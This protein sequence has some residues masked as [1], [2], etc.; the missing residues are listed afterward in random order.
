MEREQDD[1][2]RVLSA[3]VWGL[4]GLSLFSLIITRELGPARIAVLVSAY[5]LL[6]WRE[7]RGRPAK[8]P[9][10]ETALVLLFF[11]ASVLRF[12]L[13]HS[14]LLIV[15]DFLSAFLLLKCAFHKTRGDQGQI[16]AL[17][18]F[19]LLS[20]ATLAL[21]FTFLFS[22][23]LYI[24][25]LAWT[26]SLFTLAAGGP[27]PAPAAGE[28]SSVLRHVA[29]RGWLVLASAAFFTVFIFLFFPR[30]SLTV[31]QGAFLG[32]AHRTGFTENVSLEGSGKIFKDRRIVMRVETDPPEVHGA[33]RYL[34]GGSLSAFDG[35]RWTAGPAPQNV[36]LR[37]HRWLE[38]RFDLPGAGRNRAQGKEVRSFVTQKIY[39]EPTDVSFLFA[40]P[41]AETVQV[42]LPL[43]VL[44]P[45]F[46]LRRPAWSKGRI[47]Y[48]VRSQVGRPSETALS[49][50]GG[51]AVPGDENLSLPDAESPM[52]KRVAE[53]ARG[54]V[55]ERD[56]PFVKA[57]KLERYVR[58]NYRY[59]LDPPQGRG[60]NPLHDFLFV[61]KRGTCEHYA[62]A[63]AVF[64]RSQGVPARVATGFLMSEKNP[65]GGYYVV[66]AQDAHAWVEA[67]IGGVW[68][69]LDPTPRSSG[70]DA[71]G[72]WTSLRRK[73]EYLNFLWNARV[74]SYDAETQKDAAVKA[75]LGSRRL[76]A[77]LDEAAAGLKSLRWPRLPRPGAR[78]GEG[79][80][81]WTAVV[82]A[83]A[84]LIPG[85]VF[86]FRRARHGMF[87]RAS[88]G[89][90]LEFY[91]RMLKIL[92][93][94][95]FER[96][97]WE[98]PWEFNRRVAD[99]GDAALRPHVEAI[100]GMFCRARYA[101]APLSSDD[102]RRAA[103]SLRALKDSL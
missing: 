10:L 65:D 31:F 56:S 38:N 40:A 2:R 42:N 28:T 4:A 17:S 34:R 41:W 5:A 102:L 6:A 13:G 73:V 30:L 77:R 53:L 20:A 14:F 33:G 97:P 29:A 54:V 68:V 84:V 23:V 88:G 74:L 55:S 47:Q 49:R 100:T 35:R 52:F 96:R 75:Y 92:R 32:A 7:A 62:S 11:A 90:R 50:L 81:N 43:V 24:L 15:A 59:T 99:G 79:V 83:A 69:E 9:R 16:I 61:T 95:G 87:H 60:L 89:S 78:R 45:D 3:S 66:R 22:F 85:A 51:K 18:F 63:L 36:F 1:L 82:A 67:F 98:T 46:S 19:L 25:A 37:G 8:M 94:R 21:D 93:R 57:R 72:V 12:F 48:E 39:M 26:L 64:L 44:G 70:A 71:P 103:L 58:D 76:S 80:G 27:A 101:S 86:L 91:A